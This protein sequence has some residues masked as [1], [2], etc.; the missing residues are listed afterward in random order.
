MPQTKF[1]Q[2]LDEVIG[3]IRAVLIDKNR[4]Y[5]DSVLSP[6]RIFSRASLMEQIDVRLDDKISRL[7]SAQGDDAEDA[8]L[9]LLG[10]LLIKRIAVLRSEF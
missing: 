2:D 10:Y 6:K 3:G 5:G 8:E 7:A 4:K 1:I 9:D